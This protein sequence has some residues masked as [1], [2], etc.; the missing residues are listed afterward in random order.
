MNQRVYLDYNATTPLAPQVVD[1]LKEFEREYPYN[2]SSLH[3]E[4]RKQRER[5]EESRRVVSQYFDCSLDGIIFT[6]GAT[7]SN[8]SVIHST[9][10]N[11]KPHQNKIITLKIEHDAVLS[12]IKSLQKEGAEIVFLDVSSNGDIDLSQLESELTSNTLLVSIMMA[13]NETGITHPIDKISKLIGDKDIVFHSDAACA[14]GKMKI[15]FRDLGLDFMTFS[16]HKVYSLPGVGVILKNDDVPYSP[17]LLGGGHERGK[18]AGTENSLGVGSLSIALK[19]SYQDIDKEKEKNKKLREKIISEFNKFNREFV[20]IAHPQYQLDST[21]C[22]SFPGIDS[23]TLVASLDLEGI[24]VSGG[25]A[26]QSGSLEPS[27]VL[28]SMNLDE[29]IYESAIRISFGRLTTEANID[30]LIE[31]LSGILSRSKS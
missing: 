1:Y 23:Q 31:K 29:R 16:G 2:A 20:V 9:W 5:I 4:G 7:E 28:M 30:Y 10:K 24:S 15:S 17:L 13:N 14:V 8:N 11:R 18:R 19:Y 21:L 12:P 3:Y 26:C 25:A 22:V 6:S 27:H